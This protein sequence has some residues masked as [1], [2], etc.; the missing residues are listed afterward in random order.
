MMTTVVIVDDEMI[1]RRSLRESC[2]RLGTVQIV[3]EFSDSGSALAAIRASPPDIVFLDIK[4]D[5]MTGLDIA[6]ALDSRGAPSIVFVTAY[7]Q[8]AIEAFDLSAADYLVKPFDEMRFRRS[9]VRACERRALADSDR[10]LASISAALAR[11]SQRP[12][13]EASGTVRLLAESTNGRLRVVE[14]PD[15]E[16]AEAD[17]NYVRLSVGGESLTLRATLQQVEAFL[18]HEAMLR[19]SRSCIVN[20]KHVREISRMHRGDFIL[21]TKCG[22][23]V[24]CSVGYRDAV[25]SYWEQLRLPHAAQR[26][27]P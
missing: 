8:Y 10:R 21:V 13:S 5:A 4:I 7:D 23:T 9:F 1:A 27:T 25:R 26:N 3:G 14:A 18:R 19:I 11:L 16:L 17:R 2:E 12:G 24:T 22:R 20:T 6:R 15:I